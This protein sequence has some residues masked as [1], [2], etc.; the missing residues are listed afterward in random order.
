MQSAVGE[1]DRSRRG[2]RQGLVVRRDSLI[3][4][5]AWSLLTAN[6][7]YV[8]A[9]LPEALS[10]WP[11][12]PI[13]FTRLVASLSVFLGAPAIAVLLVSVAVRRRQAASLVTTAAASMFALIAV[14]NRIV[15]I[16]VLATPARIVPR[17]LDLYVPGSVAN[18]AEMSAWDFCLGVACMSAALAVPAEAKW[19]RRFLAMTG[20]LALAGQLCYLAG[21]F[22]VGGAAVGLAGMLVSVAAWVPGLS[23]IA[24]AAM[25]SKAF[26]EP[27]LRRTDGRQAILD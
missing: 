24:V 6:V 27:R 25:V 7:I 22:G 17:A 8:A 11:M 3:R 19:L 5:S 26:R 20:L 10:G 14:A 12:P 18:F 9:L 1:F 23:A 2:A 13:V 21:L 16:V 4:W 15:Q